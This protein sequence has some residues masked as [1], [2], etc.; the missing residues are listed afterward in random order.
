MDKP[1]VSVILPVHNEADSIEGVVREIYEELRTRMDVR[2]VICEDGSR[3]GTKDVLRRLATEIPM[4]LEMTDGRK[5]Y[6]KAVLDGLR[7][8]ATPYFLCLDSDGQCD[9]KDFWALWDRV[10]DAD[11]VI[12]NRVNRQDTWQ[13]RAQSRAFRA[14]FRRLFDVR[15]ADP[16]CPFVLGRPDVVQA[17]PS[18]RPTLEQGFWWEFVARAAGSGRTIAEVPVKHRVRAAGTTKV[19]TWKTIPGIARSHLSGLAQIRREIEQER[20]APLAHT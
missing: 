14:V 17:F 15:L 12:G 18:E 2:F 3:D 13:R 8:V 16:S 1:G 5:G 4:T 11:V 7:L 19:Y 6:S 20:R 10:D 9:P